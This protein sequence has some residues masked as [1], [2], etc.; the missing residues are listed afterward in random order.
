MNPPSV[1]EAIDIANKPWCAPTKKVIVWLYPWVPRAHDWDMSPFCMPLA[2]G[3][4]KQLRQKLQLSST[5]KQHEPSR[6]SEENPCILCLAAYVYIY[7]HIHIYV[8]S[9]IVIYIYVH[10]HICSLYIAQAS[11]VFVHSPFSSWGSPYPKHKDQDNKYSSRHNRA[12]LRDLHPDWQR[13]ILLRLTHVD[14]RACTKQTSTGGHIFQV[15]A[16][17]WLGKATLESNCINFS[18][19]LWGSAYKYKE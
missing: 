14:P 16:E 6:T 15:E 13:T 1:S 18:K 12:I 10:W 8:L 4:R 11:H 3:E 7:I 19:P 9:C 17:T 2:N 5:R